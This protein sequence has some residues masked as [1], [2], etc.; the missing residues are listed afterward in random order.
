MEIIQVLISGI[1]IL[2]TLIFVKKTL[3]KAKSTKVS[4]EDLS[5]ELEKEW[6]GT[7]KNFIEFKKYQ[8]NQT[9]R[10]VFG[11]APYIILSI[12]FIFVFK[13][14]LIISM[15]NISFTILLYCIFFIISRLI[16]IMGKANTN[17]IE[18]MKNLLE[19]NSPDK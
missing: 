13:N 5:K 8:Y 1:F 12:T 14:E 4:I 11:L 3:P 16:L 10:F 2:Y 18:G 6:N 19:F 7:T 9:F 15:G 17:V